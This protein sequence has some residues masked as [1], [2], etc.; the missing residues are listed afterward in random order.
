M[1]I[2]TLHIESVARQRVATDPDNNIM[3]KKLLEKID[4]QASIIRG[5]EDMVVK[6][7]ET[8]EIA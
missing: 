7:A 2:S 1:D 6:L 3:A 4:H 8:D 5:L